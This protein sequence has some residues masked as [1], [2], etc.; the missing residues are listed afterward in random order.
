MLERT[1]IYLPSPRVVWAWAGAQPLGIVRVDNGRCGSHLPCSGPT[2]PFLIFY[3]AVEDMIRHRCG[4]LRFCKTRSVFRK[5]MH[6][7]GIEPGSGPWQGPILPLD[8]E[9][10]VDEMLEMSFSRCMIARWHPGKR[11]ASR[12]IAGQAMLVCRCP[13]ASASG[14]KA[15]T[16]R[17]DGSVGLELSLI[18]MHSSDG[19]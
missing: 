13:S 2:M 5:W 9:C 7:P 15:L 11:Y 17:Y 18:L 19:P 3:Q 1:Q 6:S 4:E 10:S 8:Q 16:R 12:R 14:L